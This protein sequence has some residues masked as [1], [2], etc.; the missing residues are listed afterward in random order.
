MNTTKSTEN[1]KVTPVMPVSP[2][3]P[4]SVRSIQ[5]NLAHDHDYGN[6]EKHDI[7]DKP[8]TAHANGAMSVMS[9]SSMAATPHGQNEAY[10]NTLLQNIFEEG[11]TT[12]AAIPQEQNATS[13]AHRHE[14]ISLPD[15]KSCEP[16]TVM[17]NEQQTEK[18]DA[19]SGYASIAPHTS[20][21]PN[22]SGI[23]IKKE[24][25]SDSDSDV[26]FISQYHIAIP[27]PLAP[28][29][30]AAQTEFQDLTDGPEAEWELFISS[31]TPGDVDIKPIIKKEKTD[32]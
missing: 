19:D 14:N 25:D 20:A 1:V 17:S 4:S 2:A 7:K 3:A 32:S 31:F 6:T 12:S 13:S 22:T 30:T 28:P 18:S 23:N 26:E 11:S 29:P 5:R 15:P 8:A 24:Y 10:L 21:V 9:P 16:S 27:Q